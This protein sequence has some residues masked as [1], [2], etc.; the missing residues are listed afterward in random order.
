MEVTGDL[1]L[2]DID[3]DCY[4]ME[5]LMELSEAIRGGIK[6]RV[7]EE[8]DEQTLLVFDREEKT[9]TLDR[10][11]SGKG[12]GGI[13]KAPVNLVNDTLQ[14]RIFVDRSSVEVFLQDGDKVMTARIYP[15]E[16]SKGVC[17][18]AEGSMKI[19]RLWK[20]DLCKSVGTAHG[21][22]F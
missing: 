17:F 9:V 22:A 8:K 11:K 19:I 14:L 13:R 16:G 15:D 5:V 7:H 1:K 18:F 3:G 20:W 6:L 2:Q 10:N 4:E 21:A 12:P